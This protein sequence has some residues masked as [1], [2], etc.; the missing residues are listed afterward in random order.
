MASDCPLAKLYAPRLMELSHE[1]RSR[2]VAFVG[3]YSNAHDSVA[4]ITKQARELS[5]DFP[6]L[7]DPGNV[8][9]DLSL[10][11]RTPEVLVLDGKAR[12]CYRGAI[13]DQYGQGTRKDAPDH[14][15]L[16]DALDDLLA[17]RTVAVAATAVS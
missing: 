14:R 17:G 12:I 6:L 5:L 16:R 2:G 3:I 15:Y 8:V 9:A 7:R 11:E 10:I 13:D 1:Y 4:E